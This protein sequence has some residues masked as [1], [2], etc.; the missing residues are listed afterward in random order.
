M[1][2][3][4]KK[5]PMNEDKMETRTLGGEV[6]SRIS[7][8][9]PETPEESTKTI[10]ATFAERRKKA[11]EAAAA[12]RQ[13][14]ESQAAGAIEEEKVAGERKL[15]SEM[16]A[17]RGFATNTAVIR[18]LED[19]TA[20]RVRDLQKIKT[21]LLLS[22]KAA[23]AATYDNLIEKEQTAVTDA[24]KNY[25][26]TLFKVSEFE[27]GQRKLTLEEERAQREQKAFETP[28]Q[29]AERE[30]KTKEQENISNIKM[31]FANIPGI[32]TA[33]SMAEVLKLIG[34]QLSE[35]RKR[36]IASDNADIAYK[37]AQATKAKAEALSAAND[38]TTGLLD[39]KELASLDRTPEKKIL[40]TASKLKLSLDNYK[41]LLSQYGTEFTGVGKTLLE[42]AYADVKIK[43]KEQANLGA[44]TGPDIEVMM[45]AI[46][47][48][49]GFKGLGA[50]TLGGG[51]EGLISGIDSL[52]DLN[53]KEAQINYNK[54]LLRN[55]KYGR[56]EYV[57]SLATPFK[58]PE[59]P[60]ASGKNIDQD[61][62]DTIESNKTSYQTR[63]QLIQALKGAFPE[64]N[65]KQIAD[66]VYAQIPDIKKEEP[67]KGFGFQEYQP[68]AFLN[69]F[70]TK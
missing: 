14:I 20:K 59:T 29:K 11:E 43:W 7:G 22:N 18:Q 25:V 61:L 39:D 50:A 67:K 44:L 9:L 38:L 27:T 65:E 57:T 70:L 68:P 2:L 21:E 24:R 17:R 1:N 3:L 66:K 8:L 31:Q 13:L 40:D 26:D 6:T 63:E 56:S 10:G 51:V 47:P 34:P 55:P 53:Q 36:Q 42:S 37:T 33:T 58:A 46:K 12:G 52:L 49:T 15:T 35:D 62:I 32:T 54:L 5:E 64:L 4:L 60:Q 48:A 41:S 19:T 30:A 28:I 16:E 45:D 69:R 23:E